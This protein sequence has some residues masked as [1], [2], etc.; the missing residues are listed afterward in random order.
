[1]IILTTFF[2]LQ[3][4]LMKAG[5]DGTSVNTKNEMSYFSAISLAPVT[6][7]EASFED[8][9]FSSEFSF[10]VPVTPKEASFEDTIEALIII[11]LAP[12]TPKE[13]D[14]NDNPE[15]NMNIGLLCPLS[16]VE[17]DF[18]DGN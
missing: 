7:R 15:I 4:G 18:E 13:A 8:T 11:N 5:N 12:V 6:P 3:I 17:A 9:E 16:P 1:M 2:A 14:F 10:L